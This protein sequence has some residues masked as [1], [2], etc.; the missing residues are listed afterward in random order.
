MSI[1]TLRSQ[2]FQCKALSTKIALLNYAVNIELTEKW[3]R[4]WLKHV[5]VISQTTFEIQILPTVTFSLHIPI[6]KNYMGSCHK[7]YL[8]RA[9]LY[10]QFVNVP[11]QVFYDGLLK[12]LF[13]PLAL[14]LSP[15][16]NTM[17]HS[18][19]EVDSTNSCRKKL[20]WVQLNQ[21]KPLGFDAQSN[22]S[23]WRL[24][25]KLSVSYPYF[26]PQNSFSTHA[27]NFKDAAYSSR[28]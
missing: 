27:T 12:A 2:W 13:L 18:T 9:F 3:Q 10:V 17:C 15:E 7:D 25:F 1:A 23:S 8:R 16:I 4:L 5:C 28:P 14:G 20:I 24:F 21:I 26:W 22:T 19:L 6:L 11:T